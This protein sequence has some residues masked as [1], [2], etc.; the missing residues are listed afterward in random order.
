[1]FAGTGNNIYQ[2]RY[3]D[4]IRAHIPLILEISRYSQINDKHVVEMII[5]LLCMT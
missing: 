5:V 1:M 4:V 2:I 3:L